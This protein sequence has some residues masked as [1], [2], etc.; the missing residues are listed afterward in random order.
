M[1]D[2]LGLWE[3]VDLFSMLRPSLLG[4]TAYVE[5][6]VP[7]LQVR[8]LLF[9]ALF[10]LI[11]N[12]V[13]RIRIPVEKFFFRARGVRL[14]TRPRSGSA[15]GWGSPAT[16]GGASA[17]TSAYTP[18]SDGVLSPLAHSRALFISFLFHTS[19]EVVRVVLRTVEWYG[20]KTVY[21]ISD[22]I[23]AGGR[24]IGARSPGSRADAQQFAAT[25]LVIN[26]TLF[27]SVWWW[28]RLGGEAAKRKMRMLLWSMVGMRNL[29]FALMRVFVHDAN[30][31]HGDSRGES[32]TVVPARA[33]F[34]TFLFL[35]CMRIT[36]ALL[37]GVLFADVVGQAVQQILS[38]VFLSRMLFG[39]NVLQGRGYSEDHVVVVA[40]SQIFYPIVFYMVRRL[41]WIGTL[42]AEVAES[43]KFRQLASNFRATEVRLG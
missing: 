11:H 40:G 23:G 24:L 2:Q 1:A 13:A 5:S 8:A 31:C 14:R 34:L 22:L 35:G 16:L 32:D 38:L 41:E 43:R 7:S 21:E 19:T 39:C 3:E 28:H 15:S 26:A 20:D 33:V 30:L 12:I 6:A 42:A 9:L 4:A 37:Q 17:H 25:A 18:G 10:V 27:G 36:H 29:T